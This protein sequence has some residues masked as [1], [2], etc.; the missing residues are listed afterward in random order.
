[1]HLIT[2]IAVQ[3][4]WS[5]L[6][7]Q[8]LKT[9]QCFSCTCCVGLGNNGNIH[10]LL[11][12]LDNTVVLIWVF[13]IHQYAKGWAFTCQKAAHIPDALMIS[14]S[15]RIIPD[16][17]V[18]SEFRTFVDPC[19]LASVIPAQLVKSVP[20]TQLPWTTNMCRVR[21]CLLWIDLWQLKDCMQQNISPLCWG[22]ALRC[23]FTS[24]WALS[25][26]F[27]LTLFIYSNPQEL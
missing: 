18:Q 17:E 21:G 5:W 15:D 8:F 10:P 1:M 25:S 7:F 22:W 19:Q 24:S 27:A 14:G 9:S 20:W 2:E 6:D 23:F 16:E 26:S 12:L 3:C 4:N 11:Y 13:L